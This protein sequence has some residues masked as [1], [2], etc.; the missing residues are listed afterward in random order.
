MAHPPNP[1][2]AAPKKRRLQGMA[3]VVVF[4]A[5]GTLLDVDAAA[6]QAAA[7]P[8]GERLGAV[9]EALSRDWRRK[10][11][12]YT[13]LRTLMGDHADFET[14]TADALAWAMAA[15]GIEDRRLGERLLQLYRTL[16]PYPEAPQVLEALAGAGVRAAILSNGTPAMLGEA[17]AASGLDERIERVLS[18]ESVGRYKPVPAVYALVEREMGVARGDVLFVSANG[19]DAAGA[20]LFGFDVV[21]VN[22]ADA[23][24]ERLPG[25]PAHVVADL[26]PVPGL[27]Q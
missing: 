23:P 27:A 4:D 24:S 17:L 19:W 13:W 21:W 15:Q 26:L 25:R 14:V 16:P 7:E 2:R 8:G 6:R 18:I 11:L 9:W 12:E 22:R 1:A 5:Y 10:Q 20:A 3:A